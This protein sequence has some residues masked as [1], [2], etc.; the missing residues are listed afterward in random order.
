[1][2]A[3]FFYFFILLF[4]NLEPCIE[5]RRLSGHK[6][7][8]EFQ[9]NVFSDPYIIIVVVIAHDVVKSSLRSQQLRIIII[10]SWWESLSP[11]GSL[12]PWKL[13]KAEPTALKSFHI[14]KGSQSKSLKQPW[15]ALHNITTPVEIIKLAN[16]NNL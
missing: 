15:V 10:L 11:S 3:L 2:F 12:D 14:I 16:C 1:M 5:L 6:Q 4:G 7:W 13:H 8:S 9:C